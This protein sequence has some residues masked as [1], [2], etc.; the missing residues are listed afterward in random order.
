[1]SHTPS[2]SSDK[3]LKQKIKDIDVSWINELKVKEFEYKKTPY[4]KQIGLIAQ[5]YLD[6]EYSKY[7]L[8][9]NNEGYYSINYGNITNALIQYCQQLKDR[10]V[11]L[12]KQVK[13]MS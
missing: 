11:E 5:E 8:G 7:F 3:R 4:K 10:V 12:E 6:K 1:M 9:K 2:T 13:E